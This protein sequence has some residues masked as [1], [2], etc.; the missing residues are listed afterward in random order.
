[1]RRLL[2]HRSRAQTC[3]PSSDPPWRSPL[4]GNCASES[5]PHWGDQ[6]EGSVGRTQRR[7]LPCGPGV[8][9]EWRT[10]PREHHQN[11]RAP[12]DIALEQSNAF[13]IVNVCTGRP[14]RVRV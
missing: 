11:H 6:F 4:E 14:T 1:M 13:K 10:S 7:M 8:D 12:L 9:P 5:L 2:R 3:G